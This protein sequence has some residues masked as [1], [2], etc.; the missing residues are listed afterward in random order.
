MTRTLGNIY[1]HQWQKSLVN[2]LGYFEEFYTRY[3]DMTFLTWNHKPEKLQD[4]LNEL[5]QKHPDIRIDT[6]VG[7]TAIFLGAYVEN[8]YGKLYTRVHHDSNVP[9]FVLPY[10]IGHPRLLYR[11]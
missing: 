10:V 3:H 4:A 11:Q 5:N 8:H 7:S 9:S 2:Q 6:T 1:L